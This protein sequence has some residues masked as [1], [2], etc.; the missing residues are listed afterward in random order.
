MRDKKI[1]F[2]DLRSTYADSN[3]AY[4]PTR[5]RGRG[6]SLIELLVVI[7]VVALLLSLLLPALSTARGGAERLKCLSNM[8]SVGLVFSLY[9]NDHDGVFPNGGRS[10]HTVTLPNVPPVRI[11]GTWGLK[12]GLWPIVFPD[13]WRGI[14]WERSL[15]CPSQAP[16]DPSIPGPISS[17]IEEGQLQLPAYWM[18]AAAWIA[19]DTMRA[20]AKWEDYRFRANRLSDVLFPSKKVVMFEQ[21]GFCV[22]EPG[23]EEWIWF[24]GQT[25]QFKTSTLLADGSAHRLRRNDGVPGLRSLVPFDETLDGVRGIDIDSIG[26]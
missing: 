13:D 6:F 16:F 26:K 10:L 12:H 7:M 22:D 24:F 1:S 20:D 17:P 3:L 8:R 25:Q 19:S 11:G 18:S 2:F 9:S 4:S 23:S 21:I 14:Q 15:Q 5:R